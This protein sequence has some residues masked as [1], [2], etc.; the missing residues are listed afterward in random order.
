ME[1]EKQFTAVITAERGGFPAGANSIKFTTK[2]E[3]NNY[4][5]KQFE[6]LKQCGYIVNTG[7]IILTGYI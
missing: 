2:E 4:L 3:A 5:K 6:L 7:Y 1:S